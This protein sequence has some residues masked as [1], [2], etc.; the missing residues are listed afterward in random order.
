MFWNVIVRA[1]ADTI[2]PHFE[3]FK[4]ETEEYS[5]LDGTLY[6]FN[7]PEIVDQRGCFAAGEWVGIVPVKEEE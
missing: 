1:E 7:G 3:K 5:I 4:V 6:L 2:F